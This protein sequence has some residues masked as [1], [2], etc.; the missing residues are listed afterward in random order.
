MA[1]C[2]FYVV[3]NFI[4]AAINL[5]VVSF[6]HYK[7]LASVWGVIVLFLASEPENRSHFGNEMR[8]ANAK[9]T[10]PAFSLF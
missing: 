1:T 9:Y 5:D 7:I 10:E 2:A 8:N 6:V 4:A 3:I